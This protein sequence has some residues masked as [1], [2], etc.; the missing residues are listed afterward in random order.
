[1]LQRKLFSA[2]STRK[3]I[4]TQ[5]LAP[6]FDQHSLMLVFKR[7]LPT[8]RRNY[9]LSKIYHRTFCEI[10]VPKNPS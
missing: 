1:M 4:K 9:D 5:N 2:P 6:T 7:H 3:H 8:W 10:P